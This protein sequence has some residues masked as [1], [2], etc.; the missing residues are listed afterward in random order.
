MFGYRVIWDWVFKPKDPSPPDPPLSGLEL[1]ASECKNAQLSV[2]V[3]SISSIQR[4]T[5]TE[6]ESMMVE[7][8]VQG[9]VHRVC[10]SEENLEKMYAD[11]RR[12]KLEGRKSIHIITK[13]Q[14]M[15]TFI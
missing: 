8:N 1:Y 13:D 5:N 6:T 4:V 15:T 10:V 3:E 12:A 7:I 2:D 9:Y 14:R 11:W